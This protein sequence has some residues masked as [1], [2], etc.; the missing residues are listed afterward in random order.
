MHSTKIIFSLLLM[1]PIAASAQE[2]AESKSAK[3]ERLINQVRQ[4]LGGEENLNS[5]QSL[6]IGGKFQNYGRSN[7]SR[8]EIKIDLLLPDK[9]L[10]VESGFPQQMVSVTTIQAMNGNQAWTDRKVVRASTDDGAIRP[11]T[12]QTQTGTPVQTGTTGMRGTTAEGITSTR[13]RGT[14]TTAVNERT[15]LGMRIPTPEGPDRNND[16]EQMENSRRASAQQRQTNKTAPADK[17]DKNSVLENR[18]RNEF[19]AL[20]FGWLM[21]SPPSL[22]IKFNYAEPVKTD[23]MQAEAIDLISGEDF[24]ALLLIDR[25]KLLPTMI[26]Y[27]DFINRGE[28]YVVSVSAETDS[29]N[30]EE[31]AVQFLFS[32]YRPVMG[33]GKKLMLPHQILKAVNGAIVS[34]WKID[35]YKINPDLKPKKFEKK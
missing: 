34:E 14:N 12:D 21:R 28:G 20:M 25:S 11:T 30:L 3:A 35:K 18:V 24:A 1:L 15:V 5:V 27:R 4:K 9:F 23:Q 13:T 8:G 26:S 22:P 31:I 29:A 6:S 7:E 19:A 32:D 10:R 16:L 2:S 17:S 33:D